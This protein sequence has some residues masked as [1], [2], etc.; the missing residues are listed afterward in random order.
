LRPFAFRLSPFALLVLL[1]V[2]TPAVAWQRDEDSTRRW[3]EDIAWFRQELPRRHINAF[4]DLSR[5]EFEQL[6]TALD[7][8]VSSLRD[9]EIIVGLAR[10]VARL[11]PRDG[12]SR[13]NLFNPALKFHRLPVNVY[14]YRDGLFVRAVSND[15]V[16]LLGTRVISIGGTPVD[17]VVQRVKTI[18]P[19]DNPMSKT[20]WSLQVR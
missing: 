15:Y 20:S 3:H 13:V 17:D 11:G 1:L 18:T 8:R 19:A 9:H 6:T 14:A 10:I 16:D 5:A 12:H 4:H 7:S 2:S